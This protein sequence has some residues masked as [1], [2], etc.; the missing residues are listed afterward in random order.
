MERR[1]IEAEFY[2]DSRNYIDGLEPLV[3]WDKK[4]HR[5]EEKNY[6]DRTT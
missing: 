2:A 6:S 1:K 3:E 5:R 4:L